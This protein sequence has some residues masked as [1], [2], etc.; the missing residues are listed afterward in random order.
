MS[1]GLPESALQKIVAVLAQAPAIERAVLYGS[2]ARGTARATSDI[3]I[4]LAG[5][6]LT[7]ADKA[8]VELALDDLMLPWKIDLCVMHLVTDPA[9]LANIKH[10]SC[11]LYERGKSN[12]T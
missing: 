2:R 4:A 10:D 6:H 3:D 5:D 8:R 9:L 12:Q 7:L 1:S 11:I